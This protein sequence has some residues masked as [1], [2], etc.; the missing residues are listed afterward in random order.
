MF[1]DTKYFVFFYNSVLL[2]VVSN[3]DGLGGSKPSWRSRDLIL[4]LG[5]V[6]GLEKK[7]INLPMKVLR[8]T[9]RQRL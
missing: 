6:A 4:V 1:I 2:H 8:I 5:N 3:M 9:L 7:C